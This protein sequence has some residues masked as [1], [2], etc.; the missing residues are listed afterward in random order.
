MVDILTKNFKP[1]YEWV[2][3][4]YGL[5]KYFESLNETEELASGVTT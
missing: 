5:I 3:Q 2:M 4:S 1:I